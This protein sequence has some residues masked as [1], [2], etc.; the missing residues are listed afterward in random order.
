MEDYSNIDNTMRSY[1]VIASRWR[2]TGIT[3]DTRVI[4]YCG[5]GWR[6]SQAFFCAYLMGWTDISVYDGGWLEWSL[7]ESN[8]VERGVPP[9]RSGVCSR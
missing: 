3:P 1:P 4:F 6:A 7:D 8:P 9:G 2:D 5:T